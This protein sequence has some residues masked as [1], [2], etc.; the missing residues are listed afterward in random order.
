MLFAGTGGNYENF[1][2]VLDIDTLKPIRKP[3]QLYDTPFC[4]VV[5]GNNLLIGGSNYIYIYSL[6]SLELICDIWNENDFFK[7]LPINSDLVI[8][9]GSKILLVLSISKRSIQE[10]FVDA[11]INDMIFYNE[12]KLLACSDNGLFLINI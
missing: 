12:K 11:E 6:P 3:I 8:C 1:F 4:S 2:D 7:L 9:A 5:I 10:F